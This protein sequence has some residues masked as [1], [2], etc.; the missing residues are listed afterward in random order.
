MRLNR[1]EDASILAWELAAKHNEVWPLFALLVEQGRHDELID[2]FESRWPDLQSFEVDF[3][4][5]D[6]WSEHNYLGLIAFSYQRL[7]KK[8]KFE[9]AMSRFKAAQDYQRQIG[10]N[11]HWFAFSEAVYAA[12][13]GD[14]ETALGRLAR[15]FEGGFAVDPQLSKTWPMFE[16]LSDDPR[17]EAIMN[18]MVEHMNSERAK[19][20]LES[21]G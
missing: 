5:R 1:S 9:K 15:A 16:P 14:H 11:N 18:R 17:F 21:I 10:A 7:G 12:L 8:E 19:L 2:Y 4:E 13:A 20:R 6:G 3:P